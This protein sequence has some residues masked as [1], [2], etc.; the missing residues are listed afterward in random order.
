MFNRQVQQLQ[1][2]YKKWRIYGDIKDSY[3]TDKLIECSI[4]PGQVDF[5]QQT[6]Q[7]FFKPLGVNLTKG[8][9]EFLLTK[10]ALYQ[11]QTLKKVIGAKFLTTTANDLIMEIEGSQAMIENEQ[12]LGIVYDI[13][14]IGLYNFVYDEP[15]IV[16]DVGM[17]VGLASLYFAQRSNV[18]AV[19]GYEPFKITYDQ[20]LKNFALNPDLAPKIHAFDYGLGDKEET[21]EIEFD[22]NIKGSI[23]I[24]GIDPNYKNVAS[25]NI[26]KEKLYLKPVDEVFAGIIA[27]YPDT[28]IVVKMDCEGAEYGILETLDKHGQ[29]DRIKIIVMEWHKKGPDPIL[30]YLKKYGFTCFSRLPKSKNVGFIQAVRAS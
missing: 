11:A 2:L 4:S 1:K 29:L 15:V 30:G 16:V 26:S 25:K 17:N 12:E 6:H 9:N 7:L 13:F 28:E 23:G 5:N 27:E 3:W 24:K 14:H 21:I 22:Y 20:A 10:K 8:K 19:L 18:K